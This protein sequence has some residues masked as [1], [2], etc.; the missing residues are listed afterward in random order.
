MEEIG[1]IRQYANRVELHYPALDLV[2]R[3]AQAEWVLEAAAEILRNTAR[4]RAEGEIA[5][6]AALIDLGEAEPGA[7][8]ALRAE[9]AARFEVVPQCS[10]SMGDLDYRW[11]SPLRDRPAGDFG[12]EAVDGPMTL[13]AAAD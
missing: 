10:V 4:I 9:A 7:C 3:G 12:P 8:S 6:L 13:E 2:I 5:A 11:M 1:H